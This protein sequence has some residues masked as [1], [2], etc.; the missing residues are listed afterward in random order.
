M[1]TT[2]ADIETLANDCRFRDCRHR[3]EPGCAVRAAIEGAQLAPGRLASYHKLQDE[4]AYQV[5]Q[6]DERA[7]IEERRRWKVLTKAANKRMKE[8]GRG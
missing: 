4:Q 3:Q 5:R 6:V 1:G 7:Q 2:F 8:K